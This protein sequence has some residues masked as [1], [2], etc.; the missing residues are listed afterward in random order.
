VLRLVSIG[1]LAS[2]FGNGSTS[3]VPSPRGGR[4]AW[5]RTNVRTR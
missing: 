3:S 2:L 1:A 4:S 5:K